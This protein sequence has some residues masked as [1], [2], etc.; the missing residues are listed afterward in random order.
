[1]Q[2]AMR[3]AKQQLDLAACRVILGKGTSGVLALATTDGLPYAVPL[4]YVYVAPDEACGDAGCDAAASAV[5][6]TASLQVGS[7]GSLF[8]HCAREGRKLDLIRQNPHASFCV[9]GQD[10]VVPE[11]FTTHFTSVIAFGRIGVMEDDAAA[12]QATRLLGRKY[13]PNEDELRSELDKSFRHMVA[14]ELKVEELTGKQAIE[15]IRSN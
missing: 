14:L 10:E 8:F 7:C 9:I 2:H 5:G 15:L 1:M 12:L 6:K 11:R 3:R 13:N 4:S